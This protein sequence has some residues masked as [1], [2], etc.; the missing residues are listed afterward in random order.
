MVINGKYSFLENGD[1]AVIKLANSGKGL[2]STYTEQW[3]WFVGKLSE[4]KAKNLLIVMPEDVEESFSDE[5]EKKLFK[6]VLEEYEEKNNATVTFL[7]LGEE[8]TFSMYEGTKTIF[9]GNRV[10]STPRARMY[11]DKYIL[12]TANGEELTYQMLNI[13]PQ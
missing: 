7:V 4:T 5:L 8:S 1:V 6:Q 3:G 10:Y 13:F 2:L 9:A 12:F 11:H